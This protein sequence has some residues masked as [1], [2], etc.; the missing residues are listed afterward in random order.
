MQ[1][2]GQ[3]IGSCLPPPSPP[4]SPSQR[5]RIV[6]IVVY[7]CAYLILVFSAAS[8]V[9]PVIHMLPW[10]LHAFLSHTFWGA[11]G[12]G[13][14]MVL[15]KS[16]SVSVISR[17]AST[18]FVSS[19]IKDVYIYNF[20]WARD[21]NYIKLLAR[22]FL[23][24]SSRILLLTCFVVCSIFFLEH[25]KRHLAVQTSTTGSLLVWQCWVPYYAI[26]FLLRHADTGIGG[27]SERSILLR[28]SYMSAWQEATVVIMHSHLPGNFSP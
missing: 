15:W 26:N 18:C 13:A 6:S 23:T 22:E 8:Q 14:S 19:G 1:P 25:C 7:A 20:P 21:N 11:F 5:P 24:I 17:P 27:F 12:T 3:F 4:A 2:R 9:R 28:V 10:S 16:S